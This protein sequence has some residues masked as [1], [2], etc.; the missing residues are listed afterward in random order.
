MRYPLALLRL[1]MRRKSDVAGLRVGFVMCA[2]AH[3]ASRLSLAHA[4]I[5]NEYYQ[6]HST[7]KV[8]AITAVMS[9]SIVR[10]S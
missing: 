5:A 7:L 9:F 6:V 1:A 3:L 2:A 4:Q 10:V 8:T